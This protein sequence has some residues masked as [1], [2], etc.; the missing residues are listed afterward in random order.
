V[1]ILQLST[2]F[3]FKTPFRQLQKSVSNYKIKA[4]EK[5]HTTKTFPMRISVLFVLLFSFPFFRFFLCSYFW[6]V[7]LASGA[8]RAQ[9]NTNRAGKK[10]PTQVHII[11]S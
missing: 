10:T 8:R 7:I 9:S 6:K 5:P 2:R 1:T 11:R 3:Y 4:M